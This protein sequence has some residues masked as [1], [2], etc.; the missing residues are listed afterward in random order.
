MGS[1]SASPITALSVFSAHLPEAA[2]VRSTADSESSPPEAD[3]SEVRW[4]GS[5]ASPNT[6]STAPSSSSDSDPPLPKSSSV[7]TWVT[8]S[9]GSIMLL[10]T[11][12]RIAG[13][14]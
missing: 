13:V 7:W 2:L 14:R 10:P 8:M 5:E 4:A 9:C 1:T 6:T 3:S 11:E 12:P